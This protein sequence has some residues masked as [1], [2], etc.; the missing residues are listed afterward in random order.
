MR[1][2][3][4]LEKTLMRGKIEGRRRRGLQR[5]R[6]LDGI[7]NS[8]DMSLSKLQGIVRDREAWCAAVHGV[9]KSQ[10]RLN[11][12][13]TRRRMS[14]L[15]LCSMCWSGSKADSL[16]LLKR[17]LKCTVRQ[18]TI[19]L[20]NSPFLERSRTGGGI[21]V[22]GHARKWPTKVWSSQ[23]VTG[24]GKQWG[25]AGASRSTSLWVEAIPQPRPAASAALQ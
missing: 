25:R 21:P 2:A 22:G 17:P 11:N 7:T 19:E 10:T 1:R 24:P 13:T 8:M 4:S 15:E 5:M 18:N 16:L 20:S 14:W 12:W 9:T 6:W 3:D 23:G